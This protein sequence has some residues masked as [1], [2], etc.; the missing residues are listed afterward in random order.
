MA[1]QGLTRVGQMLFRGHLPHLGLY[2]F[3]GWKII[4]V[5]RARA[6]LYRR[7]KGA[8]GDS[9]LGRLVIA[10]RIRKKNSGK[11]QWH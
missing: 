9:T 7:L 2:Y 6:L 10:S 8:E 5:P 1:D 3:G 4:T 11:Q